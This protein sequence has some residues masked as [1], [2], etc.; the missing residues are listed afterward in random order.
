MSL[1]MIL[2]QG[3]VEKINNYLPPQIRVWGYS[4]VNNSFH[5]KNNCD[6]RVYEY[7]LPTYVLNKVDPQL[8]PLS[9]VGV[10]FGIPQKPLEFLEREIPRPD[11]ASF[12]LN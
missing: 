9:T 5:A 2:D 3:I 11:P 1:K 6:S 12:I 8:Y 10:E 4:R 7:L